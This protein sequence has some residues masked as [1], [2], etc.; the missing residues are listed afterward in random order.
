[1]R[2]RGGLLLLLPLLAACGPSLDGATLAQSVGP[3]WARL[4]VRAQQLDGRTEAS[5]AGLAASADCRRGTGSGPAT[6]PGDDWQCAVTFTPS[7]AP[8]QRVVYDVVLRPDGCWTADGPPSVVGGAT[9]V[10]VEGR[11]RV[12]P[13]AGIDGCLG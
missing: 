10:D 11:T 1:M 4:Y 12:N 6:G 2:A 7:G 5:V 13:L 9:V 8:R 3:A